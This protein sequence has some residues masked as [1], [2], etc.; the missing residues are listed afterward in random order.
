VKPVRRRSHPQD[1]LVDPSTREV[2]DLAHR[3]TAIGS[4]SVASAQAFIDKLKAGK[5]PFDWAVNN[6]LLDDTKAYGS[7]EEVY[8][9]PVSVVSGLCYECAGLCCECAAGDRKAIADCPAH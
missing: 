8:N 9:D 4:R 3:I 6:G 7:Y 1:I 5:A 2:T